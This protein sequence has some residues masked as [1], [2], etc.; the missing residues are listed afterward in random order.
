MK[1]DNSGYGAHFKELFNKAVES[2]E[3]V[4]DEDMFVPIVQAMKNVKRVVREQ[5]GY[6]SIVRSKRNNQY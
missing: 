6:V 1:K 3:L 4:Y 2:G 5:K